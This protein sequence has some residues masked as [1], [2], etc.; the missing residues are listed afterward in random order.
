VRV[1]RR[2]RRSRALFRIV[3]A[4]GAI[5]NEVGSTRCRATPRHRGLGCGWPDGLHLQ[6]LPAGPSCLVSGRTVP[7]AG[8]LRLR[9]DVHRTRV[10]CGKCACVRLPIAWHSVSTVDSLFPPDTELCWEIEGETDL[11]VMVFY[12]RTRTGSKNLQ[13]PRAAPCC[14]HVS[15]GAEVVARQATQPVT[16]KV[17]A[18]LLRRLVAGA[19]GRDQTFTPGGS[20][21]RC[22]S[23]RRRT[24]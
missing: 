7:V 14:P 11:N 19:L 22:A 4:Q 1:R 16:S 6:G 9:Q 13:G 17:V 24:S 23:G 3:H 15:A 8:F 20:R 12:S 21:S 2:R 5:F 10:Q 18:L